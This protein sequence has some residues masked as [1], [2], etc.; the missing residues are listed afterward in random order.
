MDF[1]EINDRGLVLIG[2]GKMGRALLEG[3]LVAGLSARKTH[4]FDPAPPDELSEYGVQ[5]NGPMPESPAVLVIAVKPQ[6]MDEAL[7]GLDQFGAGRTLVVSIAAG[8]TL[9]RLERAFGPGTPIVRAMPNTP[10]AIG[11]G[12][13]AFVGNADCDEEHLAAADTLL[14]AVGRT[15]RLREEREIDWVTAVSGS[16]PAYVFHLIEAM[17]DAG[18]ELGLPRD[19]ALE[20]ASATVAGAG[21]LVLASSAP[22]SELRENVTSP[23]GTT[24]AALKV[25][26]DPDT[27]LTPLMRRALKAAA[28]R[29]TDL[30]R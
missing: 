3:W 15:A 4:V 23:G 7:Q 26:M 29:A 20:L 25:L 16:G 10:A 28:D 27:G 13:T 11:S 24:E 19:Q 8:T 30:G 5:V 1:H 2:C 18:A 17:A 22:P 9:A 12:M 6:M 14:A 21:E